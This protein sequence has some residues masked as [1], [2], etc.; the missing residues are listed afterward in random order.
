TSSDGVANCTHLCWVLDFSCPENALQNST[1]CGLALLSPAPWSTDHSRQC[2]GSRP[3]PAAWL[4]QQHTT[5]RFHAQPDGRYCGI[6]G[7]KL[8]VADRARL[9]AKW[10]SLL[11]RVRFTPADRPR[12]RN[13]YRVD[14]YWIRYSAVLAVARGFQLAVH[15]IFRHPPQGSCR[16]I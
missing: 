14:S 7:F 2:G 3:V 9:L 12:Y 13:Q 15:I 6:T 5:S 8:L 16:I 4:P 11:H 1:D 10:H